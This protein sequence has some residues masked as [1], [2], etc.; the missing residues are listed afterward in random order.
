MH[1]TTM[2]LAAECLPP[3]AFPLMAPPRRPASDCGLFLVFVYD[4]V[5]ICVIQEAC[6]DLSKLC[7]ASEAMANS[8]LLTALRQKEA[9]LALDLG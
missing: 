2:F 8:A 9:E 3:V 7:P 6:D 4:S 5:A 1:R